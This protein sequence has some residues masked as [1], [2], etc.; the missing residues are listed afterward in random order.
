MAKNKK[1]TLREEFALL[2][3]SEYSIG[4]LT[5]D[6][7]WNFFEHH[8]KKKTPVPEIV[9]PEEN[10]IRYN[11]MFPKIKAKKTGKALRCNIA[12]IAKSFQRFFKTYKYD[13]DTIFAATE[14]Y[15]AEEERKN[16]EWTVRSKY[17]VTKLKERTEVS[18]LA[19]YCE[20]IKDSKSFEG[21]E[22][23]IFEPKVY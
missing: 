12:E 15:L 19:E 4:Q 13:W 7:I 18:E 14:K 23:K 22:T 1:S 11:E 9:I 3:A 10:V 17:F 20:Q 8:L 6:V 5:E 16:Y 21:D 2:Y